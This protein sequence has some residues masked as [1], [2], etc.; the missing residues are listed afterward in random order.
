MALLDYLYYKYY[1][2]A[3]CVGNGEIA[4]FQAFIM[5]ILFFAINC[6]TVW[7]VIDV[8]F[9]ISLNITVHMKI[10]FVFI[11]LVLGFAYFNPR[12]ILSIITNEPKNKP[13][14]G[15]G[16]VIIYC[17][18]SIML[19]FVTWYLMYLKNIGKINIS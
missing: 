5:F 13:F 4:K 9:G 11:L 15:N 2:F 17:I 18:S 1:K 12:K 8:L 7:G 16:L 19:L 10:G 6:I 14:R 3:I